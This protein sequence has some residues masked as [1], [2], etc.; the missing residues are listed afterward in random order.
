M[1][2]PCDGGLGPATQRGSYSGGEPVEVGFDDGQR[3]PDHA[4]GFERQLR[5]RYDGRN[6]TFL[7]QYDGLTGWWRQRSG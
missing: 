7:W 3:L 2:V 5:N 4:G 1:Q 6:Y